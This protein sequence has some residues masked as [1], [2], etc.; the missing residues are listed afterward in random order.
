MADLDWHLERL[1]RG[2]RDGDYPLGDYEQFVIR[3]PKERTITKPALAERVLHHAIMN[4]CEPFFERWLIHDTY[5]CRIGR[6]RDAALT[7]AR[8]FASRHAFF[9]KLE[10]RKYFDSIVHDILLARL[11]RLF[12]D[13]QLIALFA[14]LIGSYRGEIGVGLPI[15]SLTSQHFANFYLGW[16]DRF[17]KETLR[18]RGYV[19]YMDDMLLWGNSAG[20]L[21]D[22]LERGRVFLAD[23]LGLQLKPVPYINRTS[24]GVDFLGCRVFTDHLVLNRRSRVRFRQRLRQLE[25]AYLAGEIDELTL[26]QRGTSLVAFTQAAAV[27]SWQFRR[28]VI[29]QMPVSGRRPATG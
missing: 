5:A 9:L 14:R 11:E 4:V 12:K 1:A 10:I 23:E 13:P 21:G 18:L 19:R 3:D 22:V 17:V 20:F 6:G 8:D 24:H 15:G 25:L 16:F 2:L 27:K 28:A 7:R 26:Q 29:E